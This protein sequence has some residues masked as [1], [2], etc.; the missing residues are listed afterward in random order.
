MLTLV[1]LQWKFLVD[2]L[3]VSSFRL[4]LISFLV[5][6]L[7]LIVSYRHRWKK[8]TLFWTHRLRWSEKRKL[9]KRKLKYI[10]HMG[11]VYVTFPK[12]I[13]VY[14]GFFYYRPHPMSKYLHEA[15]QR[16]WH[17]KGGDVSVTK[18][19]AVNPNITLRYF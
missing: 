5:S 19:S 12:Q 8:H 15:I 1:D 17:N 11:Y 7:S 9:L 14:F 6:F 10:I 2:F 13:A 18:I 16:L 3:I 4:V